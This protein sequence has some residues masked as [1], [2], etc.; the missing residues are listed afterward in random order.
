MF[1]RAPNVCKN[2]GQGQS[3]TT[4]LLLKTQDVAIVDK[5]HCISQMTDDKPIAPSDAVCSEGQSL[6]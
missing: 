2:N 3:Q 4:L 6:S 1:P 5:K